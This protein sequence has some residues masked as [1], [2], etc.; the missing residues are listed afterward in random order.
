MEIKYMR[1]ASASKYLGERTDGMYNAG[2]L[3]KLAVTG[4]GPRFQKLGRF[5]VYTQED[6]DEWLENR[7]S[8]KVTS[9]SA[10]SQTRG[11]DREG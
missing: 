8:A 1:R 5:P 6:L 7:L 4:G 10:L 9:T 2:T 11:G 3:A